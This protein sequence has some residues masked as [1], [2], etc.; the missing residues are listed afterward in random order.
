MSNVRD[1]QIEGLL[2]RDLVQTVVEEATA[3][4]QQRVVLV[5]G[6]AGS[7]GSELVIQIAHYYPDG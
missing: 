3:Y 1:V 6:T 4:L 7:I 2:G 5:R